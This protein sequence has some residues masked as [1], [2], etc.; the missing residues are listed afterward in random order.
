MSSGPEVGGELNGF[1]DGGSE[2]EGELRFKDT[3]RVDGRLVGKVSSDGDLIVG[4]ESTVEGDIRVG[5]LFVSGVVRG[6]VHAKRVEIAAGARLEADVETP[7]LL[8]EE[9]AHFQGRCVME[10]GPVSGGSAEMG[11][12]RPGGRGSHTRVQT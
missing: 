4:K 2:I 3:F 10:K 9:G 8:I 6:S 12:R 7:A 11:S 1:L 5:R